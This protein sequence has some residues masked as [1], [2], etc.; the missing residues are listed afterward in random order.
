ME[1]TFAALALSVIAR[2][3][4]LAASRSTADLRSSKF[5]SIVMASIWL[6][7]SSARS[8]SAAEPL[9]TFTPLAAADALADAF[10]SA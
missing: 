3:P 4:W 7:N 5:A 1:R 9:S 2:A 6:I 10:A 8:V